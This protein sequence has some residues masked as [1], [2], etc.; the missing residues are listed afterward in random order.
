MATGWF[1]NGICYELQAQAINTH[2]QAIPPTILTTTTTQSVHQFQLQ[3]SGIWNSVHYTQSSNGAR[4]TQW[5]VPTPNP[6]FPSCTTP[7]DPTTSFINGVELGW[8]VSVVIVVAYC[9]MRLRRG[10]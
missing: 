5:S 7:N 2:F 8:A 6:F 10:F 9:I 1:N 3:S 4:T